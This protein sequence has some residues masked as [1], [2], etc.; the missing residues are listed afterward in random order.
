MRCPYC[1]GENTQV[2]DSRPTEESA[3]IRRRRACEDCGGR[4]TT[5]E[6]VQLREI[7]VVKRSGRR[8]PFDRA[9]LLHSV[10]V[11]LRKRPVE[12]E[13]DRAHGVGPGAAAGEH[14][15]AGRAL[16]G[17]RRAGHG[18]PQGPRSG[19]L[20][21]LCLR[22]PRF[23]RGRRLPGGA[24]RDRRQG[25]GATRT[26]PARRPAPR[27]QGAESIRCSMSRQG[28]PPGGTHDER[29]MG[30]ALRVARRV[31]GQ[32][33]PNPAVGAVI[34]DEA[35]GEVVARGWTQISGRPHAEAHA[36]GARRRPRARQ[37]HVRHAGALL[38]PRPL[39]PRREQADALRRG[40][41]RRRHAPRGGG[42]GGP[43]PRDRRPGRGGAAPGRGGGGHRGLRRRRPAG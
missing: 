40:D 4:F 3:A 5:F 17:D 42:H 26:T 6:R 31:L 23:P 27:W 15:R 21:A 18:R 19:G 37:D 30:L 8:E 28:R 29:M 11:A 34:A 2:K 36:L 35:T 25:G 39:Q 41:P 10:E 9:K 1:N 33:A 13:R 20:R 38:L 16:L 32:T 24:G 7:F 12:P 22:L 14:R 43:E